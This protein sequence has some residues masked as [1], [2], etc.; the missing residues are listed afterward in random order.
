MLLMQMHISCRK[1]KTGLSIQ[2]SSTLIRQK[3]Q[4][5]FNEEIMC[6]ITLKFILN[7]YF[8]KCEMEMYL[9]ACITNDTM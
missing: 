7:E 5:F 1:S 2:T 3:G 9:S 6:W 4:I 8:I